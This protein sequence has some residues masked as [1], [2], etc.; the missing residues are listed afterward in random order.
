MDV[1]AATGFGIEVDS[2]KNPNHPFV[3]H[4]KKLFKANILQYLIGITCE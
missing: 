1:I 4:A 3:V 2:Q